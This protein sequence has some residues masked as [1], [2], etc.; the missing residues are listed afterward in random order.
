MKQM[1]RLTSAQFDM[2][3]R[4]L[5][6]QS[7]GDFS[8][9]NTLSY[10]ELGLVMQPIKPVYVGNVLDVA[11]N[12]DRRVYIKSSSFPLLPQLTKGMQIDNIRQ[13]VEKFETEIGSKVLS[14]GT[15]AFVRASFNT[16][17]K[18][19]A[20]QKAVPVFDDKGD[21]LD[22][23]NITEANTLLLPRA[24]FR[25]QQDVPY[26]REKDSVNIGTQERSVLFGDLLGLRISKDVTAED[27]LAAYNQNYE[28]I[29]KYNQEKLA[30]K[31]GLRDTI[32]NTPNIET[33]AVMPATTV[34]DKVDAFNEKLKTASPI[35]KVSLQEDLAD[36]VGEDTLER[37]N[38]INKNFDDIIKAM[39]AAKMNIFFDETQKENEE[40]KKCD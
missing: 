31:L 17:N 14:D 20:V 16:A 7:Q 6:A 25:I 27:L 4:K 23:I 1:G 12:L 33:L 18:V 10:E 28:E 30:E 35:Q 40:F 11:D 32:I 38:F 13:A 21:V 9:A 36:E 29:F 3:T 39:A 34:F 15:P 2:L 22:D 19:G 5:T 37:V 24:N 8:P 26:K